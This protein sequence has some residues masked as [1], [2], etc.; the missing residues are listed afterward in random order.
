MDLTERI[1]TVLSAHLGTHTADS[2]ARH[3]CAKH[4]VGP[5]DP[6]DLDKLRALR[7]E[8]QRGLVAF[9]GNDRARG[10]A[11]EAPFA[12]KDVDEVAR[13]CEHAGL[14]H[15]IARLRPLGVVKG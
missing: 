2:V 8:I 11:E 7:D 9:V 4:G 1:T 13:T 15:R 5:E 14:S 12:Y 10:L 6:K 3:L